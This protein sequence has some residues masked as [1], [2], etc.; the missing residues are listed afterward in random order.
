MIEKFDRRSGWVQ[1]LDKIVE[2]VDACN[3]FQK[4]LYALDARVQRWDG[5]ELLVADMR[6]RLDKLEEKH[7]M[8]I[9]LDE[10]C[11]EKD[12]EEHIDLASQC[13]I[14]VMGWHKRIGIGPDER[15]WA[16]FWRDSSWGKETCRVEEWHPE[17]D[18]NQALMVLNKVRKD[19]ASEYS[20]TTPDAEDMTRWYIHCRV[21]ANS[22]SWYGDTLTEAICLAALWAAGQKRKD[23]KEDAREEV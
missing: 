4:R 12:D 18:L 16:D 3:D 9:S 17:R 13:A 21:G 19:T 2:L 14:E 5:M 6:E 8:R 7:P 20:I 23:G 22:Q 10:E 15:A 1:T 11:P